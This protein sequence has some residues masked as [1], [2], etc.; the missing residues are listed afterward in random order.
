MEKSGHAALSPACNK[1]SALATE[2]GRHHRSVPVFYF[3]MITNP[4]P[5]RFKYQI[6]SRRAGRTRVACFL[7]CIARIRRKILY[8]DTEYPNV[9]H[10]VDQ[11]FYRYMYRNT[12]QVNGH[13]CSG[14]GDDRFPSFSCVFLLSFFCYCVAHHTLDIYMNRDGA[15][16]VYRLFF[17]A[18]AFFVP[19]RRQSVPVY[20]PCKCACNYACNSRQRQVKV[21]LL[22]RGHV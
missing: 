6:Q 21:L 2:R 13:A 5:S 3:T 10:S 14:H 15:T 1:H 11:F 22:Q 16:L 7:A 12:M 8:Q 18:S 4:F 17:R 20:A 19:P 9:I